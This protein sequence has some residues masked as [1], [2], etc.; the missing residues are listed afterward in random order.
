[1]AEWSRGVQVGKL[2]AFP[3][4]GAKRKRIAVRHN[5]NRSRIFAGPDSTEENRQ[6]KDNCHPHFISVK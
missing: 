2:G 1:M 5:T 3:A 6:K 4:N